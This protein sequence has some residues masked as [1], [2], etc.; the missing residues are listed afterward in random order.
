MRTHVVSWVRL[1]GAVLA[2]L[3]MFFANGAHAQSPIVINEIMADNETVLDNAGD[4]P[5]WIE[6]LNITGAPVDLADWSLTDAPTLPR[7]FVFPAGT[8]IPANGFLL[9]Y[10]DDRTNSPGLHTGFGLSDKGETLALFNSVALGVLLADQVAFGLQLR[11]RSIGRVPDVTGAFTLTTPTPLEPNAAV[12]LGL[13]ATL[14]INEWSALNGDSVEDPDPDWF[15]LYNPDPFPVALGGLVLTDQSNV[16]ATNQ[17]LTELSFI[18]GGGFVQFI[19][20]DEVNPADNVNFKLSSTSGDQIRLYQSDRVSL[21]DSATFGP[22]TL[23]ISQGRL[24]DGSPNIVFFRV[25][26]PTPAASNFLPLTNVVINEVLTHTDPPLEDAIELLNVSS[27]P[28]DISHWWLS[29]SRDDPKKFSIP[30]GTVLPP[31]GFVVFYEGVGTTS[32]FNTS[33]TGEAP[34]FTLNSAHGDEL[35]LFTGDANGNLTGQR[36][37]ID[38]GAAENGVSFGRIVLSTGEGDITALS[39]RTFG[40]DQPTSVEQFRTGT[41]LPN[42]APKTGAIVISEI[43][44]HPPDIISGTNILDNSVDEFIELQNVTTA[45]VPLFDPQFPVNTWRIRGEVDFDFP[46]GRTLAAGQTLLVVNFDPTVS[47]LLNAFREKF[48][49]PVSTQIFGPYEGKLSNGGATIEVQRPDVPQMSPHPDAGFVPRIVVDQVKY[50]DTP[51]WPTTPDGRGYSLQKCQPAAYGGD[52]I[53]WTGAP[54]T[55]GGAGVGTVIRSVV[56]NGLSLTICFS[57]C[58]GASC[59]LQS[60]PSLSTPVWTKLT[61]V[62]AASGGDQCVNATLATGDTARFFRVVTPAQP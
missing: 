10:C 3:M 35:Y 27:T 20:D 45:L 15:E 32:G 60:S 40:V 24:P 44:Y 43:F 39:A 18:D 62:T 6:L 22:Q 14:K 29:N 52:P 59:T 38:F 2:L 41:G 46:E 56:R 36:R 48:G 31:G 1:P 5:D 37:G 34:D 28:V 9:I 12:L 50:S 30:P 54:V 49:V 61:D 8:V 13:A 7:R 11:D 51:P 42:A 58:T 26:H 57:A 17:A 16:P 33:G 55:P 25:D 21:I 4:F 19:A 47:V 23:N 53:N